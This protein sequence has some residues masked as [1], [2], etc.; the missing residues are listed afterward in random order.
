MST[1]ETSLR[2]LLPITAILG[3]RHQERIMPETVFY[4]ICRKGGKK[5]VKNVHSSLHSDC[6]WK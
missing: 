2:E 5:L 3:N 1:V 6:C 4:L